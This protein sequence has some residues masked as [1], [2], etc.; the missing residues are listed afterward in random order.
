MQF[1]Y[2][3]TRQ[4]TIGRAL[5]TLVLTFG[6]AFAMAPQASAEIVSLSGAGFIQQCPCSL[7]GQQPEIVKGVLTPTDQSTVFAAVDFPVNGRKICSVTMVY[8]DIN[9]NDTM[10][11]RLLRKSFAV[12]SNVANNPAVVATVNSDAGVVNTVRKATTTT[13]NGPTINEVSGFYYVEVAMPTVNLNLLGVQI[14]H[15]LTCP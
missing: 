15:R 7:S 8:Q 1:E 13:I 6:G 10:T 11:A 2:F 9:N 12:G 14:D 3:R 4:S 5:A